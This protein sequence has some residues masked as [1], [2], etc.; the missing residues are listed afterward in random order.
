MAM[1]TLLFLDFQSSSHNTDNSSHKTDSRGHTL[2]QRGTGQEPETML[3]QDE[4]HCRGSA[5]S[6][7]D[8]KA[9]EMLRK[10]E[11]AQKQALVSDKLAQVGLQVQ[12]LAGVAITADLVKP[13]DLHP[14]REVRIREF[15]S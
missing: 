1:S 5:A 15:T 9:T 12:D 13:L 11:L 8:G 2:A 6:E 4:V 14:Y 3:L 7:A 10:T